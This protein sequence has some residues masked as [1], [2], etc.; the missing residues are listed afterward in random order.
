[1]QTCVLLI[2]PLLLLNKQPHLNLTRIDLERNKINKNIHNILFKSK[3]VP[4]S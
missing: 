1:M 2:S 3:L 4:G